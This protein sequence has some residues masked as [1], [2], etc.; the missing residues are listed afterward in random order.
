MA[1]TKTTT[2]TSLAGKLVVDFTADASKEANVTAATSG[3][4]YLVEIDNTANA[5]TFAYLKI[6]DHADATPSDANAGIPTWQ[7]TAPKGGK[8]T[9][10][11]PD[12]QEYAA[13]VSIWCTTNPA[14]QN[15][16]SPTNAVI[17]KII[18]S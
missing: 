10:A 1:V 13:G 12:G 5:S 3:T 11:F 18:A 8:I 17:V 7:L 4:I 2:I 15:V 6:R 9:Y 14:N 16:S